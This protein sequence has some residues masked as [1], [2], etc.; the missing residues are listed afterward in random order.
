MGSDNPQIGPDELKNV[1]VQ[2]VYNDMSAT[3]AEEKKIGT[4]DLAQD[5]LLRAGIPEL[6]RDPKTKIMVRALQEIA[7]DSANTKESHVI[8]GGALAEVERMQAPV[9]KV[10]GMDART[11]SFYR[12]L[13]DISRLGRDSADDQVYANTVMKAR[14]TLSDHESDMRS[15]DLTLDE[16]LLYFGAR[17]IA[18]ADEFHAYSLGA[19]TA[20]P[21]VV[22][23]V[24]QSFKGGIEFLIMLNEREKKVP[25]ESIDKLAKLVY[26]AVSVKPRSFADLGAQMSAIADYTVAKV[27]SIGH[28]I[29]QGVSPEPQIK[30]VRYA[31]GAVG[32]GS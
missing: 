1:L 20:N 13:H 31:A 11:G 27:D 28:S 9:R 7:D 22:D 23:R 12:A 3:G 8:A 5:T 26:D 10:V 24:V 15:A 17:R 2:I 29:D 14:L 19:S 21:N 16:Q 4:R 32:I 30:G 18:L 25:G 6:E